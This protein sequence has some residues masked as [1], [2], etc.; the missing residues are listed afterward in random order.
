MAKDLTKKLNA[1]K[2]RVTVELIGETKTRFF[3]DVQKKGTT[4]SKH[5]RKIISEY[6][7]NG[8]MNF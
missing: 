8:H 3:Q 1:F 4:E 2:S 6:Y 5:A 7:K